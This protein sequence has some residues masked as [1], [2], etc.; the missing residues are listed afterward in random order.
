MALAQMAPVVV[1]DTDIPMV[2]RRTLHPRSIH[3]FYFYFYF[4]NTISLLCFFWQSAKRG[5]RLT[6]TYTKSRRQKISVTGQAG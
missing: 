1:L 5:Q 3:Y 4:T 6:K 2:A